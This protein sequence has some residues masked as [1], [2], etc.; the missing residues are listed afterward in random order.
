VERMQVPADIASNSD[1]LVAANRS[2]WSGALVNEGFELGPYKI[3]HV[4]RKW[5]MTTGF[6]AGNLSQ[7]NT[8]GAYAFA[9]E[10]AGATETGHCASGKKDTDLKFSS[11]AKLEFQYSKLACSCAAG[12][13]QATVVVESSGDD[14]RGA[15]V[16][17][18]GTYRVTSVH[19]L[20]GGGRSADAVGYRIDG[21][22][23]IG[24]AEILHPGQVWLDRALDADER[25]DI[26]C[27]V[28]G[29]LLYVPKDKI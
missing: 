7:S 29:L 10:G 16:T 19:E 11:G 25:A 3:K 5:D 1:V 23:G 22:M 8:E 2:S 12:A 9:F 27:L 6:V 4:D 26:A 21:D 14:Y 17:S 15:L 20:V 13:R 18:S 24:A 28:V